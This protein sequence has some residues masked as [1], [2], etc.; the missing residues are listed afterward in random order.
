MKEILEELRKS[1]KKLK[2]ENESIV[3][4]K[5]AEEGRQLIKFWSGIVYCIRSKMTVYSPP[6]QKYSGLSYFLAVVL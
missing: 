2:N 3:H 5:F 4:T 1:C 6:A